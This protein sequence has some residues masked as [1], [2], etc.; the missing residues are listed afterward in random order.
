[1]K[2]NVE[3]WNFPLFEHMSQE[4]GLTLTEGQMDDIIHVVR[5]FNRFGLT[6]LET[7]LVRHGVIQSAA[8]DD[9]E[10]YDMG[11]TREAVLKVY[12][13]VT[14]MMPNTKLNGASQEG[15]HHEQR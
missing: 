1:M 8:I 5:G 4:H 2:D 13:D 9:A 12:E 14:G 11:M 15:E 10:G 7:A 6:D 3:P